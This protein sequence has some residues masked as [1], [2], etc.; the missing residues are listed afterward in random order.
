MT[1]R[2]QLLGSL[3]AW[4]GADWLEMQLPVG[5]SLG[6]LLQALGDSWLEKTGPPLLTS[7]DALAPGIV[8]SVGGAVTR[9]LALPLADGQTVQVS[10][11]LPGG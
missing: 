11:A 10:K 8:V 9:D 7:G 5:C 3:R 4:A 2:V 1:A 6:E